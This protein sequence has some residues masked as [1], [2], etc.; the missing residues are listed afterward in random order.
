MFSIFKK[1]IIVCT[2]NGSFHA[3]E[4]FACATLFLWAEQNGKSL[5]IIRTRDQK[6]IDQANIVV[7]VGMQYEP[8][9]NRFDHHQIGGAGERVNRVPFA[10]FGLVWQKYGHLISGSKEIAELVENKIVMPID[11]RDNGKNISVPNDL[12]VIE[13]G[14]SDAISNFNPTWLENQDSIGEQFNRALFFAKKVLKR[15]IDSAKA[16]TEGFRA[17]EA[18]IKKQNYPEVLILEKYLDWEVAVSKN[19]NIKFVVYNHR[20]GRDWCIQVGRDNLDD[21]DS[22]RSSLPR[23]WWGLKDSE[24]EK[25]CGV[26]GSVF[27]T[28]KGW[29]ATTRSKEA[30]LEMVKKALQRGQN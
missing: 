26:A 20:N 11:A 22:K 17:T 10:S 9:N 30:A 15:E 14:V 16:E 7:D 28:N 6:L 3:D 8:E 4:V 24:L 5:K 29:F 2:H 25:A 21:Y 27:C 13:Y 12:G 18:E 23:N 1:K 19:K